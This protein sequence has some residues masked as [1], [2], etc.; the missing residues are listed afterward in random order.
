MIGVTVET[1][2][3]AKF[4]QRFAEQPEIA[5]EAA[6][7]AVND[8]AR[9]GRTLAARQ[10]V[11]EVNLKK[12]YLDSNNRLAVVTFARRGDLAAEIIGRDRATS[13]ARYAT[14][15]VSFGK[16]KGIKVK[17]SRGGSAPTLKRAFYMRLRRGR[18][19]ES[20]NAN[21]GL[22]VRLRKGETL[23]NSQK[24]LKVAEGL[25]LLYGPSIDQVFQFVAEDILDAVTVRLE[26][27]FDRQ[28]ELLNR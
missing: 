26:E 24:A 17:V 28:Y 23:T 3:L 18:S 19:F 14:T 5:E 20:E 11:E 12:S 4:A 21:V 6:R 1:E 16:Q 13:L 25:Y 7:R 22:A 2:G 9:Y 10:I 27:Q 8:T 15:P